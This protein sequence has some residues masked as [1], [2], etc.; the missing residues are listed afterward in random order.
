MSNKKYGLSYERKRKKELEQLGYTAMRCRGSLGHFDIVAY[1]P[2]SGWL[3]ESIKATRNK[4]TSFKAELN[5][6]SKIK[7]PINTKARLVIYRRNIR[8]VII[9]ET[10]GIRGLISQ[11]VRPP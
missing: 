1:S 8:E 4:K 6:L 10:K 3:L 11:E 7:L 2:R 9:V 5:K